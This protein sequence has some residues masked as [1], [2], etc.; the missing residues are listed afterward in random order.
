VK[1]LDFDMVYR[2]IR[3]RLKYI[4]ELAGIYAG[5]MRIGGRDVR[6]QTVKDEEG[7]CTTRS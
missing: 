6:R 1:K 5:L 4:E 3:D 7:R 2:V